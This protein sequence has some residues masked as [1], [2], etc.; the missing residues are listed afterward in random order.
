MLP[1]GPLP[2]DVE[3][4]GVGDVVVHPAQD[5]KSI[6]E[7]ELSFLLVVGPSELGGEFGAQGEQDV[8]Q[9]V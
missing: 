6:A 7:V 1:S 5:G 2:H 8:R 4:V 3:E 9:E